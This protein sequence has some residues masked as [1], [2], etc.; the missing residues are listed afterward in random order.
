M[1]LDGH[2]LCIKTNVIQNPKFT[3]RPL[4]VDS[5]K[6][7]EM[8]VAEIAQMPLWKIDLE[9]EADGAFLGE[10]SALVRKHERNTDSKLCE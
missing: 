3:A 10:L 9:C 7:A 6:F 8:T 1:F 5:G 4:P 2:L